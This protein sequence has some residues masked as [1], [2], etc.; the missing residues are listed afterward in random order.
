MMNKILNY[1]FI[2]F[3]ILHSINCNPHLYRRHNYHYRSPYHVSYNP[4]NL[5]K[6]H[7]TYFGVESSI[8][9]DLDD[10]DSNEPVKGGVK[11]STNQ[12]PS[13]KTPMK[14]FSE[15]KNSHLSSSLSTFQEKLTGLKRPIN[16]IKQSQSTI[17]ENLTPIVY[18][19]SD[20]NDNTANRPSFENAE[21]DDKKTENLF[22]KTSKIN[23][24]SKSTTT[25][26]TQ[27]PELSSTTTEKLNLEIKSTSSTTEQP[28]TLNSLNVIDNL[29][30]KDVKVDSVPLNDPSNVVSKTEISKPA[31]EVEVA[32]LDVVVT[33]PELP[34]INAPLVVPI[35]K[36]DN[37]VANSVKPPS[38]LIIMENS[39]V[40]ETIPQIDVRKKE[41]SK[42]ETN[43]LSVDISTE[44]SLILENETNGPLIN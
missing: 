9:N 15:R 27:I 37:N 18:P 44:N 12:N 2:L 17:Q 24:K 1:L 40:A 26:T 38:E 7:S 43:K 19:N 39:K 21:S 6:H 11:K 10:H 22:K 29:E 20:L 4:Y 13:I 5:P 8:Y 36:S 16:S 25:T 34:E 41:V 30:I 31:V 3:V 42:G 32:K 14:V 23:T 33:R 28:T 35:V